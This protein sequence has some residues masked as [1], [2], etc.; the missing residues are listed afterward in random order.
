MT[1]RADNERSRRPRKKGTTR[2]AVTRRAEKNLRKREPRTV[3]ILEWIKP[4]LPV[5]AVEKSPKLQIK[6]YV[7][8][9]QILKW[10]LISKTQIPLSHAVI[11]PSLVLLVVCSSTLRGAAPPYIH[12]LHTSSLPVFYQSRSVILISGQPPI[13]VLQPGNSTNDCFSGL[14]EPTE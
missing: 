10:Q 1:A 6:L 8:K 11:A 2:Y 3:K 5:T 9:K 7:C 12:V 4:H 13:F 14:I